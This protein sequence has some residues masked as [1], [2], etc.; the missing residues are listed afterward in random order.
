[1]LFAHCSLNMQ[2]C[3]ILS[4]TIASSSWKLSVMSDSSSLGFQRRIFPT[5][6][7]DSRIWNGTFCM[8]SN[9]SASELHFFPAQDNLEPASLSC[10]KRQG[11]IWCEALRLCNAIKHIYT[12]LGDREACARTWPHAKKLSGLERLTQ[13]LRKGSRRL[14]RARARWRMGGLLGRQAPRR[15]WILTLDSSPIGRNPGPL[16]IT[17]EKGNVQVEPFYPQGI[18]VPGTL[19]DAKGHV[20][21]NLFKKQSCFFN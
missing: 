21:L 12:I 5:L 8:Q 20:K 17:W 3:I 11:L 13:G 4:Q 14:N 19:A 1:M 6:A 7:E 15:G 16:H 10:S 18:S 2:G 9:C